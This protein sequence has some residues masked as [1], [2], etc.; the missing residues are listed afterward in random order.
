MHGART[1]HSTTPTALTAARCRSGRPGCSHRIRRG[2]GRS[3]SSSPLSRW[4][5][6]LRC[7]SPPARH[8]QTTARAPHR[9]T[10]SRRRSLSPYRPSPS[11][12]KDGR[13]H[14]TSC[15]CSSPWG[16]WRRP[17]PSRLHTSCQALRRPPA[18]QLA[19][20]WATA[21]C[22]QSQGRPSSSQASSP[23]STR[24]RHLLWRARQASLRCARQPW[25]PCS[26]R[27]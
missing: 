23:S 25:R 10:S 5:T 22:S 8:P 20:E 18:A 26:K 16:R 9:P 3:T 6:G 12:N 24:W 14:S 4:N 27:Q 1:Q 17:A 7:A 11:L 21:T 19:T 15:R 2:Y 13:R